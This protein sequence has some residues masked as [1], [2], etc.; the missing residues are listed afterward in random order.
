MN[1]ETWNK[2]FICSGIFNALVFFHLE[3]LSDL[4]SH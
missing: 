4:F 3:L 2:D 1:R